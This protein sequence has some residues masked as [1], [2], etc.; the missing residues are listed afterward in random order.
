[1]RW[2]PAPR[3]STRTVLYT[4]ELAARAEAWVARPLIEKRSAEGLLELATIWAAINQV[5]LPECIRQCQYSERAASLRAYILEFSRTQNPET[6]SE[7]T[8]QLAQ[9]FANEK[10][11]H[12]GYNK[13]VDASNLTD[14]DVAYF[15]KIG[16]KDLFVKRG[17][18]AEATAAGETVA[19]DS[20]KPLVPEAD[21]IKEQEAHT[22]TKTKAAEALTKEKEAHAAAK[23]K[24]SEALK[25]EKE[26]HTATKKELSEVQKQLAD[27]QKQVAELTEKLAQP[28][29]TS[30][31]DAQ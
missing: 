17:A 10:L 3:S 7:S 12:E 2:L 31:A 11:V 22:A 14:E 15:Q 18:T 19:V 28:A 16:R 13:V 20:E 1:M 25:S 9:A 8:Y 6:M 24:A 26:A 5:A 23:T 29:D 4:A 21:L 27:A 30:Q